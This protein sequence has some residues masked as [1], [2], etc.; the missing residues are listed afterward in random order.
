MDVGDPVTLVDGVATL[1]IGGTAFENGANTVQAFYLGD[2]L[3]AESLSSTMQISNAPFSLTGTGTT[4][5]IGSAANALLNLVTASG[6]TSPVKLSCA[7][8]PSLTEAA[9]FVNPSSAIGSGP[10]TLTVNTTPAHPSSNAT[11][12]ATVLPFG[13]MTLYALLLPRLRRTKRRPILFSLSTLTLAGLLAASGCSSGTSFQEDHGTPA[14]VYN[15]TVT[16]TDTSGASP[17]TVSVVVPVTLVAATPL[18]VT[19]VPGHT[20]VAQ[21]E[22]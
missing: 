7:L 11:R 3:Y 5:A 18:T 1:S 6:F 22:S 14:G 8:P 19:L 12:S 4:A 2:S 15:V 16:A 13:A 17:Y 21:K 9:C 10:A 20:P